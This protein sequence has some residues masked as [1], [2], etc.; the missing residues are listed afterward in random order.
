M[1]NKKGSGRLLR[2]QDPK[3][4]DLHP[5]GVYTQDEAGG[6]MLDD[7]PRD[8]LRLNRRDSRLSSC[9]DR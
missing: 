4:Q 8:H 5:F 1:K 3:S 2:G 9:G 6:E 7:V